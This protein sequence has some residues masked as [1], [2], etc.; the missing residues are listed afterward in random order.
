MS[1]AGRENT[2]TEP[3]P[4]WEEELWSLISSGDGIRCPLHNS[5]KA[6]GDGKLCF[7]EN[8]VLSNGL[9]GIHSVDSSDIKG[10]EIQFF[11]NRF[12]PQRPIKLCQGNIFNLVENLANKYLNKVELKQPPIATEIITQFD[13]DPPV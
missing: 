6:A 12:E 4:D 2:N 8:I 3:I 7:I 5:C 11:L 10:N 1:D 13:I 9:Y